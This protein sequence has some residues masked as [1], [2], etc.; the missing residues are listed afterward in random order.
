[1]KFG[2]LLDVGY[3]FLDRYTN[4]YIVSQCAGVFFCQYPKQL[5]DLRLRVKYAD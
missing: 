3:R 1:M 4:T 5:T 2:G